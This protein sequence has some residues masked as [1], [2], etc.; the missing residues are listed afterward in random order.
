MDSIAF[1]TEANPYTAPVGLG[2]DGLLATEK[3]LT[4]AL[5]V[6]G[7]AGKSE[8]IVED[9][10]KTIVEGEV[11]NAVD[12]LSKSG[13]IPLTGVDKFDR[14]AF[15]TENYEKWSKNLDGKNYKVTENYNLPAGNPANVLRDGTVEINHNEFRYI[16]MLHESRHIYQDWTLLEQTGKKVLEQK[17]WFKRDLLNITDVD[18]Y[19]Y[20]LSLS[21]KYG[22]SDEY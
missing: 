20:E 11:I 21:K 8:E 16:D 10:T 2:A 18:A 7:E 22:F 6:T 14:L 9:I 4:K 15:G 13:E 12:K 17:G 1:A 3:F 5:E 19:T